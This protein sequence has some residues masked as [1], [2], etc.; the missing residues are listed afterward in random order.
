MTIL[1]AP[2]KE[3]PPRT[4]RIFRRSAGTSVRAVEGVLADSLSNADP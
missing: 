2:P 1:V 3:A 4:W